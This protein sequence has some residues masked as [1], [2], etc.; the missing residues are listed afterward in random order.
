MPTVG[1]R[2]LLG[3]GAKLIGPIKIG[4]GARIGAGAV[5]LIDVPASGTAVGNPARIVRTAQER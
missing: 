2:V 4:D 3:A 5:V 1:D